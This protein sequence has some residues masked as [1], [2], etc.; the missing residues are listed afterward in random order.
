MTNSIS[1]SGLILALATGLIASGCDKRVEQKNY[2]ARAGDS[3]LTEEELPDLTGSVTLSG[4]QIR[5]A[6]TRWA[7]DE[8]L[9]QEA[10][11]RGIESSPAIQRRM[12]EARRNL[13][14]QELLQQEIYS[15]SIVIRDDSVRAYYEQRLG[16]FL[17]PQDF[18]KINYVLFPDREKANQFRGRLTKGMAWVR[19]FD[20]SVQDGDNETVMDR[21]DERYF[22]R[23]T[24]FPE[25]LWRVA[26]TLAP[27]EASFPV[28]TD[29]GF[30]ILETRAILRAGQ[31]ADLS[32]VS[33]DI[34]QRLVLEQRRRRYQDYLSRL[35]SRYPVEI[36]LPSTADTLEEE[37]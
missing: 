34:R 7:N 23:E 14:I 18:V 30:Y 12:E 32:M 19:A 2:L 22:S 13:L 1:A 36:I 26:L 33:D 21:V 27:G 10:I 16:E 4:S 29:R 31:R 37:H 35:R 5:N 24:L 15:D 11:R 17:L 6:I 28:R 20:R 25:E 8:I 9:Q 3:Y